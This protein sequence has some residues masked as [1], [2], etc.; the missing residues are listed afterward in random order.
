MF[1]RHVPHRARKNMTETLQT[2]ERYRDELSRYLVKTHRRRTPER[3]MVLE[4]ALALGGHFTAEQVC[5]ALGQGATRVAV[6]TVYNT[7][8]LLEECGLAVAHRFNGGMAY[9]EMTTGA[10]AHHHLICTGCGAVRDVRDPELDRFMTLRRYSGFTPS[11]F[12]MEV[13]G[14]CNKCRRAAKRAAPANK[15]TDKKNQK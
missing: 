13:Q 8:Q 11:R 6:G 4:A 5:N 7:L 3:F 9:Y 10:K 14:L 2:S 12:S 1:G 15:N